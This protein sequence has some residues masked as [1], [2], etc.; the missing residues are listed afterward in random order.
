VH[1]IFYGVFL[2]ASSPY[3]TLLLA[4]TAAVVVGQAVGIA[5]YRRRILR[6]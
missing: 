3:T 4:G 5:L 2:R 6:R 1:A